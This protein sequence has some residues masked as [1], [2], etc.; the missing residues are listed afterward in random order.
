MTYDTRWPGPSKETVESLRAQRT[1]GSASCVGLGDPRWHRGLRGEEAEI[2]AQSQGQGDHLDVMRLTR[3]VGRKN[4]AQQ[5][6]K[7]P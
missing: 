6:A 3:K 1:Q 7:S 5:R 2:W 4:E